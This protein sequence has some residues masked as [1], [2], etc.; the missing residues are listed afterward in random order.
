MTT[1]W[2]I[3]VLTPDYLIEGNIDSGFSEIQ[4]IL[5]PKTNVNDMDTDLDGLVNVR[6][7]PTSNLIV[8]D[9]PVPS[10]STKDGVTFLQPWTKRIALI[11]RDQGSVDFLVKHNKFNRL[12]PVD[13]YAGSYSINGKYWNNDKTSLLPGSF[14]TYATDRIVIQDARIDCLVPGAKL[15][16][17]QAPFVVVYTEHIQWIAVHGDGLSYPAQGSRN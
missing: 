11:P 1:F 8:P 10:P 16:G 12:T 7:Q 14:H 2:N 15:Q 17:F 9:G 5:K 4:D 3:Q 6:Y 13:I